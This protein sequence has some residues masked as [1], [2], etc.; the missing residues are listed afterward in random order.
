MKVKAWNESVKEGN[1]IVGELIYVSELNKKLANEKITC[2]SD[3][4]WNLVKYINKATG[5]E[6]VHWFTYVEEI[7]E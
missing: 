7:K 4:A 6:E 5:F 1:C 2:F 3:E